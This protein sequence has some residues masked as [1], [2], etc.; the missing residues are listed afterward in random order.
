MHQS[1]G[2]RSFLKNSWESLSA[3][4]SPIEETALSNAATRR[5]AAGIT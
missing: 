1:S 2:E 5:L 3:T 4:I